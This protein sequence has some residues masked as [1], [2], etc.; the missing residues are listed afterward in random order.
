[1]AIG[2]TS[3]ESV[4]GVFSVGLVTASF[5]ADDVFP[6]YISDRELT[7]VRAISTTL[8]TRLRRVSLALDTVWEEEKDDGD[9]QNEVG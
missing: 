5:V 4:S 9:K 3:R 1:M 7:V 8:S 2:W 6:E